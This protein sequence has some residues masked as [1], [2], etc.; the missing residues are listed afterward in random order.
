MKTIIADMK[1]Q[2][3]AVTRL[4]KFAYKAL[5]MAD[6]LEH[7]LLALLKIAKKKK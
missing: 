3:K 6:Q 4:Q 5:N 2:L 7:D 1:K